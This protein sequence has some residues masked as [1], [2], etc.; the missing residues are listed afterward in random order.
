MEFIKY[1]DNKESTKTIKTYCYHW[2][3][4]MNLFERKISSLIQST[5]FEGISRNLLDGWEIL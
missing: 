2:N 3:Y 4:F 5:T 1:L